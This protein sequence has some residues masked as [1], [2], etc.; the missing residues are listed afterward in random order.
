MFRFLFRLI[1]LLLLGAAIVAATVDGARSVAASRLVI[2]SLGDTWYR[3]HPPSLAGLQALV[4][5][6]LIPDTFWEGLLL[7]ILYLPAALVA[8]VLGA[9]FLLIGLPRHRRDLLEAPL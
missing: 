2:T 8:L 9:L 7:S 1:G 6:Y 3:A 4:R 5:E